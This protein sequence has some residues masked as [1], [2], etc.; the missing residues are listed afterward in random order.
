MDT[1]AIY[2]FTTM[3][4]Q[5]GGYLGF[6]C[7]QGIKITMILQVHMLP[8]SN[9]VLSVKINVCE[10]PH[11]MRGYC[12]HVKGA[13]CFVCQG[14]KY[15]QLDLQC[16]QCHYTGQQ[17]LRSPFCMCCFE[18][19][20]PCLPVNVSC[21]NL[22]GWHHWNDAG[23]GDHIWQLSREITVLVQRCIMHKNPINT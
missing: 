22:R 17:G 5:L 10:K 20:H 7:D 15:P 14:P 11:G 18:G 16:W 23:I 1:N 12:T 9:A 8:A 13:F 21:Y 6:S 4:H 19:T 3:G 2:F